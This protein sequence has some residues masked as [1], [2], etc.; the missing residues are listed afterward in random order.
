MSVLEFRCGQPLEKFL[1]QP[2]TGTIRRERSV[3]QKP[4]RQQLFVCLGVAM[5]E[6]G[7]RRNTGRPSGQ[8]HIMRPTIR[9]SDK[10]R[11]NRREQI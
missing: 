3:D 10:D 4:G 2:Y 7:W 6:I 11:E 8:A 9:R 5:V 1:R